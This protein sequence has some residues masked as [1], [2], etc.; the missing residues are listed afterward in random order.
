VTEKYTNLTEYQLSDIALAMNSP[1]A[2]RATNITTTGKRC[3]CQVIIGTN[4][5][6]RHKDRHLSDLMSHERDL[7]VRAESVTSHIRH[8]HTQ[9]LSEVRNTIANME[10]RHQEQIRRLESSQSAIRTDISNQNTRI[11]VIVETA[12]AVVNNIYSLFS[13]K[14]RTHGPTTSY[15]MAMLTHDPKSGRKSIKFVDMKTMGRVNRFE[16]CLRRCQDSREE[17]MASC[18]KRLQVTY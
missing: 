12:V 18:R 11:D 10:H 13:R 5:C 7:R 9:G 16:A 6:G 1:Q 8:Q 15:G 14:E 2:C 4:Y 3:N 17:K